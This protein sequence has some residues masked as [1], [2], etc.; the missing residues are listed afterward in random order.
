MEQDNPQEQPPQL[1]DVQKIMLGNLQAA[2]QGVLN[3]EVTSIATIVGRANNFDL[4]YSGDNLVALH[5]GA[6]E[7]ARMLL[8]V[9]FPPRNVSTL[10]VG[11]PKS[12]IVQ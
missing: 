8:A 11:K 10:P 1:T 7:M 4:H 3:G 9:I 6:S 12:Q 2:A 5:A